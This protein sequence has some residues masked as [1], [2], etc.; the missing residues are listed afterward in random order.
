MALG[1]VETGRMKASEQ[2]SVTGSL[3]AHTQA[4]PCSV[5]ACVHALTLS[6][7]RAAALLRIS[8]PANHYTKTRPLVIGAWPHVQII[9][10]LI[11][12]I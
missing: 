8:K 1:G 2:V 6:A 7:V 3:G 9:Y 12:L 4:A 5:H 11:A 10:P